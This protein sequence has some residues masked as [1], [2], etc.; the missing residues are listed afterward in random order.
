MTRTPFGGRLRGVLVDIDGTLVDSN[1]HHAASWVETLR[2]FGIDASYDHVRRLIG[3]GGDKLLPEV[4]GIEKESERGEA[5]SKRRAELFHEK[6]L[7]KVRPFPRVRDLIGRMRE[8]GLTVVAATS[9][10]KEE[11]KALLRIANVLDLVDAGANASDVDESKPDPDVVQAALD[12]GGL[13]PDEVLLLGD[14]PYDVAAGLSA[15]VAV[16]GVRSGGWDTE[17]LQGAV[18]VYDDAANLLASWDASPFRSNPER[19]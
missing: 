8:D 7:P 15:G 19:S 12:A 18:A 5:I 10:Q 6:Y 2:E 11:M 3:K 16:V 4:S 14:T 9:A 1:D 13:Q 17:G